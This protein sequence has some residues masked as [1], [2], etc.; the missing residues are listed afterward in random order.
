MSDPDGSFEDTGRHHSKA[1]LQRL[2]ESGATDEVLEAFRRQ[3]DEVGKKVTEAKRVASERAYEQA[4]NNMLRYV[5][6]FK[7]GMID[8]GIKLLAE[9][10]VDGEIDIDMMNKRLAVLKATADVADKIEKRALGNTVKKVEQTGTISVE[11]KLAEYQA[12]LE[13]K[14]TEDE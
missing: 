13:G 7:A 8:A 5:G 3:S 11:H 1:E 10:Q 2:V 14:V 9:C 6:T 12:Q 4:T